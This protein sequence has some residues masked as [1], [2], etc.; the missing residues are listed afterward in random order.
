MRRAPQP[1]KTRVGARRRTAR[2]QPD[3]CSPRNQDLPED[4]DDR[5]GSDRTYSPPIRR[6]IVVDAAAGRFGKNLLPP[7]ADHTHRQWT[8]LQGGSVQNLLP[9]RPMNYHRIVIHNPIRLDHLRNRGDPLQNRRHLRC[10]TVAQ[11]ACIRR[12]VHAHIVRTHHCSSG[13]LP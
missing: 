13:R 9:L 7:Q 10:T 1:K 12:G 8:L 4:D 6:D 3:T 11:S 5:G 2:R